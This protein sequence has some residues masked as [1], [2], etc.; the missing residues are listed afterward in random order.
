MWTYEQRSGKLLHDGV[1]VW[2]GYSG[3]D[4]G[5]NNPG[6][7]EVHAIGPLPQ[8]MYT[9]G[10]PYSHPHLGPVCM[11][12]EPSQNNVMFGRGDFRIHGDNFANNRSA[13]EGCI[14]MPLAIRI[15]VGGAVAKGDAKLEVISGG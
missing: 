10:M 3:H 2:Q 14:V 8:G 6:M 12:L 5:L 7:Q 4:E 11:N 13:S 15:K 9:I 1:F